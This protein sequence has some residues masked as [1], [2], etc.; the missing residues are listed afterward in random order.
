MRNVKEAAKNYHQA[1][2]ISVDLGLKFNQAITNANYGLLC[3]W[4]ANGT[5]GFLKDG[6]SKGGT[7]NAAVDQVF[8]AKAETAG[9]VAACGSVMWFLAAPN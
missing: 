2:S 5:L 3:L 4:K 1:L 6:W 7:N 9:R 8:E